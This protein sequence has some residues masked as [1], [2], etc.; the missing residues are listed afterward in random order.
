LN[1]QSAVTHT[2]CSLEPYTESSLFHGAELQGITHVSGCDDQGISGETFT[3]PEP[4]VWLKHPLRSQWLADPLVLDAS[5]Q[6]MILWT[7]QFYSHGSL[8]TAIGR[9]ELYAPFPS[10]SVAIDIQLQ[11]RQAHKAIASID[12]R[13]SQGCLVARIDEY[14][15]V[16]DVSLNAGFARNTLSSHS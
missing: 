12:F 13:D 14:E 3:A 16:I 2:P 7:E 5:F 6:L 9:L 1:L 10:T 4:A 11:D 8:P 15:C